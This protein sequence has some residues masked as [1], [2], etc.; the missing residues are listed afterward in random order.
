[1]SAVP[2]PPGAVGADVPQAVVIERAARTR[3]MRR[4]RSVDWRN[5]AIDD[6][7][8]G[9]QDR[10]FAF[11]VPTNDVELVAVIEAVH[12]DAGQLK[13]SAMTTRTVAAGENCPRS[14]DKANTARS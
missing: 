6:R 14:E 11:D 7:G 2:V 13:R 10:L 1:M 4:I 5:P 9:K 3:L 12:G 8:R